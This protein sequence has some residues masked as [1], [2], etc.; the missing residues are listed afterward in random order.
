M[1]A[2]TH[3]SGMLLAEAF[4]LNLR[5]IPVSDATSGAVLMLGLE[6]GDWNSYIRAGQYWQLPHQRPGWSADGFVKP[7]A[8]MG[9]SGADMEPNAE[10]PAVASNVTDLLE[11]EHT[12]LLVPEAL[13]DGLDVDL[14]PPLEATVTLHGGA[15][16][17]DVSV[18][19]R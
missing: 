19:A 13:A 17:I 4:D 10:S 16:S 3:F 1:A 2:T 8:F 5:P 12:R 7:F 9:P 11:G 15:D 18:G 6:R 14:R